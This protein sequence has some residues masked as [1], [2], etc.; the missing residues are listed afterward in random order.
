[1]VTSSKAKVIVVGG[2]PAGASTAIHLAR[3]GVDVTLIDRARFPRDKS[4]AEYLSPGVVDSLDELGVLP[5]LRSR[6]HRLLDSMQVVARGRTIPLPF[7]ND[8][9]AGNRPM[10]I[11]RS[12]LDHELLCLAADSGARILQEVR[13]TSPVMMNGLV[14]GVHIRH[15]DSDGQIDADFVIGADGLHSTLTRFLALDQPVRW[16]RKMG[17]VAR[18]T[19]L[20]AP[21]RDGQMHIGDHI[22]CGLSPVAE[23]EANVSL[24]VPMGFKPSGVATG[25]FFDKSIRTLPGI[26][27]LLGDARRITSVRG[28]GPLGKR[29]RKPYGPGY[30]LVGDAAGFFDPITGEGI[31]RALNGGKLAAHYAIKALQRDDHRPVGY[32]RARRRA[33]GDKQRVCEIIQVLLTTPRGLDYVT[34]RVSKRDEV[35]TTVRGILGDYTPANQALRPGFLWNLL[36]P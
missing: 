1:M 23:D 5:R 3:A 31:H 13:A 7:A 18:F 11:K 9:L 14:S 4:C 22:Y 16:P 24:V 19:D 2:G 8:R 30:L 29:V 32:R 6:E 10:G 21:I 26:K 20:P 27:R 35:L 15:G 34:A 28:L 25:E 17:L 33:F 12:V 36:R